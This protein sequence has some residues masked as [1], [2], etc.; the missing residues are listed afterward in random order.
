MKQYTLSDL[1]TFVAVVESGSFNQAAERLDTSA[2]SVSRRIAALE[3]ALGTRLINRTTRRLSLTEAGQQYHADVRD[4]LEMVQ[5][6]EER[7]HAGDTE[8]RGSLRV[9]APMSFGIQAIAPLVPGF[10]RQYPGLQLDLQLEDRQTDLYAEG[11]DLALRIGKLA[12]SGLVATRLCEVEFGYFA[13]PDYLQRCGE[14]ARPEELSAHQCLHYSLVSRSNEWGIKDGSIR[15]GGALSTN[16]GEVLLEAALQGLGIVALPGFI[17][18][19]ALAEKRLKAILCDYA[20]APLGLYAVHPSRRFVP[21]KVR[22][23]IDYLRDALGVREKGTGL[24]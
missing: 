11:I 8:T 12:D 17:V 14:P 21:A 19:R 7:M 5:E 6:A 16:N 9:A 24:F 22:V 1:R 23:L 15:V 4:I 10:L 13:A 20:P 2:A 18:R 3:A